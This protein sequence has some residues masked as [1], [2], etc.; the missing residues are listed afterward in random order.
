MRSEPTRK[1]KQHC[2]DG[3][4]TYAQVNP[5]M[6]TRADHVR[7]HGLTDWN[8]ADSACRH[9]DLSFHWMKLALPW[10]HPAPCRHHRCACYSSPSHTTHKEINHACTHSS[11][12]CMHAWG[13]LTCMA[14]GC[15][16]LQGVNTLSYPLSASPRSLIISIWLGPLS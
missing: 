5:C 16:R 12:C 3:P 1:T 11:I 14:M 15:P 9:A 10:L 2:S 7:I 6:P 4:R 13:T 8:M